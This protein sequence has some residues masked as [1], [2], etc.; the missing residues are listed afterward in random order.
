MVLSAEQYDR[1]GAREAFGRIHDTS[2]WRMDHRGHWTPEARLFCA[3]IS[4]TLH[5]ALHHTQHIGNGRSSAPLPPPRRL[6]ILDAAMGDMSRWQPPCLEQL[7][8][9][10]PNGTRLHYHGVDLVPQAVHN[11]DRRRDELLQRIPR[12]S[13]A[14]GVVDLTRPGELARAVR[15]LRVDVILCHGTLQHLENKDIWAV[16]RSFGE[17]AH[18]QQS[19]GREAAAAAGASH[20]P[21]AAA[22]AHAFWSRD[23]YLLA[24]NQP[25]D[26]KHPVNDD[27]ALQEAIRRSG[28]LRNATHRV[29]LTADPFN[30]DPVEGKPRF[31][32]RPADGAP[33]GPIDPRTGKPPQ[34]DYALEFVRVFRVSPGF[35]A[36]EM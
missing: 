32:G 9:K 20:G 16:L 13:A 6:G 8:S 3:L 28:G 27:G 10:L 26:S 2:G 35:A 15:G 30:M 23:V 14:Y 11:A 1:E 29:D 5:R 22:A 31:V 21:A 17:V 36:A 19:E 33:S 12:L 34:V 18:Q 25:D 4:A 24:D 7:V